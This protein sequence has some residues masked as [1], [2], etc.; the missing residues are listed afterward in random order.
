MSS[1]STII[2]TKDNEHIYY[3]HIDET[4]CIEV[5]DL[6]LEE[7]YSPDDG[8]DRHLFEIKCDTEIGRFFYKKIFGREYEFQ[9]EG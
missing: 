5:R 7:Y 9:K 8:D 4:I 2:L 3:D 1:K 6:N